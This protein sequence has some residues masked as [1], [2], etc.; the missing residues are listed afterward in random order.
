MRRHLLVKGD[1]EVE[2]LPEH[3]DGDG[4]L[5]GAGGGVVQI[6]EAGRPQQIGVAGTEEA[7]PGAAGVVGVDGIRPVR[8][9]GG[10]PEGGAYL[11]GCR[12]TGL[13]AGRES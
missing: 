3:G 12:E 5:P 13:S 10:K 2:L 7:L 11:G 9:G 1:G 8:Y 6:Q 4:E